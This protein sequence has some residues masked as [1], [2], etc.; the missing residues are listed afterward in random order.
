M[1]PAGWVCC[2]LIVALTVLY[3][4]Y[5][6]KVDAAYDKETEGEKG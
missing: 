5:L 1:A 6:R 2:G 3:T 4:C